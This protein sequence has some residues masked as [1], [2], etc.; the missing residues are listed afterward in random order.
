[1]AGHGCCELFRHCPMEQSA[2]LSSRLMLAEM[3][4]LNQTEP[5]KT[6]HNAKRHTVIS[7]SVTQQ[8]LYKLE[9][10]YAINFESK[11]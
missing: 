9:L 5:A 4:E 1:M 8:Q 7:D 6:R 11:Y 3:P 10:S 2:E